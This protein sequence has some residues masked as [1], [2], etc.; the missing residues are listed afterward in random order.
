MALGYGFPEENPDTAW[1]FVK[2]AGRGG[3]G[4]AGLWVKYDANRNII[5]RQIVKETYLNARDWNRPLFWWRDIEE[6]M[7]REAYMQDTLSNYCRNSWSIVHFLGK[8]VYEQRQM[9]RIFMEYCPLV[10]A[11]EHL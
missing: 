2:T 9:Y 1:T 3:F 4:H 8:Q 10:S 7:P 6:R 5:D 11:T